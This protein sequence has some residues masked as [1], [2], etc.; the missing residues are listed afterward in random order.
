MDFLT[1]LEGLLSSFAAFIL[2]KSSRASSSDF[3]SSESKKLNNFTSSLNTNQHSI[4]HR[5]KLGLSQI[6]FNRVWPKNTG[7]NSTNL[8]K[9]SY[10]L[11]LL[12]HPHLDSIKIFFKKS[13]L[14]L[15]F[16][17]VFHWKKILNIIILKSKL[18]H[19]DW[20]LPLCMLRYLIQSLCCI[21]LVFVSG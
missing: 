10:P 3:S 14:I 19:R 2:V 8:L 5:V 21:S 9:K 11:L 17:F 7:Y 15:N 18:M 13:L 12:L 16:I 4:F 1:F 6:T 20:S